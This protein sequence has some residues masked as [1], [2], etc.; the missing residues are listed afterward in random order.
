MQPLNQANL[1]E[2]EIKD[3]KQL[4]KLDALSDNG[5]STAQLGREICPNPKV[6]LALLSKMIKTKGEYER[7]CIKDGELE[8]RAIEFG[9]LKYMGQVRTLEVYGTAQP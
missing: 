4:R 8:F 7:L 2:L 9:T 6:T 3:L 5:V 1:F